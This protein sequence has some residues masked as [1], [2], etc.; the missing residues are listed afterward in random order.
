MNDWWFIFTC[1]F[2][3]QCRSKPMVQKVQRKN[4]VAND[5][6][7]E[8]HDRW[9][10]QPQD[11][12]QLEVLVGPASSGCCTCR[13]IFFSF[14][15]QFSA[16]MAFKRFVVCHTIFPQYFC[17]TRLEQH[18]FAKPH[19]NINHQ[20]FIHSHSDVI[21]RLNIFNNLLLTTRTNIGSRGFIWPGRLF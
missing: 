16:V 20:S 19:V 13:P 17:T 10:L 21:Y 11:R 12:S 3:K 14:R 8:S 7:L 4:G 15:L 5:E 2:A 1:G 9:K 18:C 6:A